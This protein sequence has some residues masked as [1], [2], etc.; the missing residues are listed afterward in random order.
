[1]CFNTILKSLNL[2]NANSSLHSLDFQSERKNFVLYKERGK[3]RM[4]LLVLDYLQT[5]QENVLTVC[6]PE[7]HTCTTRNF[8]VF[9]CVFGE[10]S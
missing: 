5:L 3:K 1:M 10:S 7:V 9:W 4:D 8:I 6:D 2:T